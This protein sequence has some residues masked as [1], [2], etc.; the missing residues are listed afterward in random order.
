[1]QTKTDTHPHPRPLPR[2][3]EKIETH[4]QPLPSGGGKV[5][6]QDAFA[7]L[8]GLIEVPSVS[9]FESWK[10]FFPQASQ[11]SLHAIYS[12]ERQTN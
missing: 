12:G 7:L 4:P 6:D 5:T 3:G 11:T 10:Y 8:K 9:R 2:G 1:M